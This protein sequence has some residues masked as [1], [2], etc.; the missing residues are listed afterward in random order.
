ML[1][2]AG[3]SDVFLDTRQIPDDFLLCPQG[4]APNEQVQVEVKLPSGDRYG[5]QSGMV[6]T[7]LERSAWPGTPIS[8]PW[9]SIVPR[10]PAS[11]AS[12]R[13]LLQGCSS[14]TIGNGRDVTGI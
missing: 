14:S 13:T 11:V 9:M 2:N 6:P 5:G 1:I 7:L 3:D 8:E 12:Q 4:F 10:V